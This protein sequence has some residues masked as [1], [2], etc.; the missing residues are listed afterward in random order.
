[1]KNLTKFSNVVTKIGGKTLMKIK[2]VSPSIMVGVG[3]VGLIGGTVLACKA[4]L[5]LE[6]ILD[7]GK[8]KIDK[9]EKYY[10]SDERDEKEYTDDDYKKDLAISYIQNAVEIGKLYAPAIIVSSLS[11]AAIIGAHKILVKRL[12]TTTAAFNSLNKTF[13]FY[14]ENVVKNLGEEKDREFLYGSNTEKIENID[15]N[16][17]K[18]KEEI[19]TIDKDIVNNYS[20]YAKFFD[21]SSK[22]F[23][24]SNDYNMTFLKCQ[25]TVAN[26][27]LKYRGHVFL[28]E[29]YDLLGIDR[30]PQ[31]A[32]VGW[33][34]GN[35]DST[36][37]FDIFNYRNANFV[38]GSEPVI[39]LDFNVD[40]PIYDLI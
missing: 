24:Q 36:I 25:E 35:K 1:M 16:G 10:N 38:N 18:S 20:M 5:K 3:V 15:E 34:K 9:I 26:D 14:R 17:K 33:V 8:E 32:L 21:E 29:V 19:K 2:S 28:N 22:E 30:T 7:E 39:L 27:M 37:S 13:K 31:G 6:K 23:T 12:L 11:I 40:G 4:T